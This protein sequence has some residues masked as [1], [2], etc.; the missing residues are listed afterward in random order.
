[1]EVVEEPQTRTRKKPIQEAKL[2]AATEES[3]PS[4]NVG[5]GRVKKRPAP[6]P[7]PDKSA[8]GKAKKQVTIKMTP[9]S[10]TT[11]K[12]RNAK[13]AAV[14]EVKAEEVAPK[15]ATRSRK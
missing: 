8:L 7:T 2:E 6:T 4:P 9:T 14:D 5:T 3:E 13:R 12:S 15:R 1:M 10:L 11:P